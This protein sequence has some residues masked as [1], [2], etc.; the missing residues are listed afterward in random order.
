MV[1]LLK[2]HPTKLLLL[3]ICV[4]ATALINYSFV[5]TSFAQQ[6]DGP[7]NFGQYLCAI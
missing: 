6:T 3:I 1:Q 4:I 7:Q 5:T 2:N